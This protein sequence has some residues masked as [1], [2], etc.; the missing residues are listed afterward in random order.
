MSDA[1]R[2]Y[3][4][5]L[6]FLVFAA[7]AFAQA[8][9]LRPVGAAEGLTNSF[10]HAMAQ[11]AQGYLWI[12]TGEGVGR[13]DGNQVTMFTQADGLAENFI[14]SIHPAA[15]GTLWFGHNEGGISRLRK[16]VFR[17]VALDSLSSSTINAMVEDGHGGIWVAA[18]NNGILHVGADGTCRLSASAEGVLWYSLLQVGNGLLLAGASDGLHLLRSGPDGSLSG[19]ALLDGHTRAPVRSLVLG[20]QA[21]QVYAGT[22]GEG[23]LSFRVSGGSATAPTTIGAAEGLGTLQVRDLAIGAGGQLIIGTFGLGAYEVRLGTDGE[24]ISL[25]HYDASNGLETD[26]VS[27]VFTDS[28]N[29]LW[30]AR[31]GLGLARLL[32]RALVYYGA[33]EGTVQDVQAITFHGSDVWF[34]MQGYILHTRNNDMRLVDTLGTDLGIPDDGITA[35]A[36]GPDGALW[37]GTAKAGLYRRNAQGRFKPVELA[38][39]RMS[40]Q[41]H[42]ITMHG[43]ETWVGTS[44]GVY[45]IGAGRVRHLTTENGL[46]HNQ[47]NALLTDRSG[48]VWMACNNGGVSMARDEVV[49]SFPLT[50]GSNIFHVT[51]IAEDS[52]GTLWFS[53]NGNGVR[54]LRGSTVLGLGIGQGLR[55]DYCYAIAADG[56]G[57]I[58]TAHRG[59]AS[60]IDQGTRTVRTFDKQLGIEPDRRI[61]TLAADPDRNIWFGTDKGVLRYDVSK[62]QRSYRPPPISITTVKV[63]GKDMDLNEAIDLPPDEYRIQ[64]DFL[65]ISLKA[66][67]AVHY[68]YKLEGHDPEW[69]ETTQRSAYYMRLQDGHYIFRVQAAVGDGPFSIREANLQLTIQAPVWKRPWFIL[70]CV[71]L[72]ILSTFGIIRLREGSQRRAKERLQRKLDDRTRE[73]VTKNA[74]IELKNKDI[75]D[76]INYAQRIQ[77]AILPTEGNLAGQL[78]RSFL[79]HRPRNIVSG[80]FHWFKRSGD[81][82]I[83]ACAD[84]TGH[85]VPGAFMSMIGSMLLR[86]ITA[87]RPLHAPSGLLDRLDAE[88]R[89]V[90]HYHRVNDR[91]N[92][93]MDISICELDLSTRMLRSAAAMH[94]IIILHDGATIRQRGT[95]RSIGGALSQ[96]REAGFA[97][98][99]IQLDPGDRVYVFSDGVPDQFGGANGK[100][101]M[102]SGLIAWI[103]EFRTL[104]M[105]GQGEAFR[106]RFTEWSGEH[107]QVDDVLLIGFEV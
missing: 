61:N 96:T 2:R 81:K 34:G 23:V 10:V 40:R 75:T 19:E 35:L 101:L 30:F 37:V 3:L 25:Q 50:E 55:S 89:T 98:Q 18:Q 22:E 62:D 41:V 16:G 87:E 107:D 21:G 84:C 72:G 83:L 82:L 32:D 70:M 91:S 4:G 24:L 14:S 68:R 36:H 100:K 15:D 92:D 74:E 38:Q 39:D 104:P 5:S 13:F 43:A 7:G 12:G 94:D 1:P 48:Q 77:Q 49:R 67:G 58:W 60:R 65:G 33:D 56:H 78:P 31:F 26:N 59:G 64:F 88:L 85:G 90:L 73:L 51:G 97:L 20:G 9:K 99:G 11:D 105:S 17:K 93:G 57:G 66:P 69:T 71:L 52:S 95:R 46:M 42:A 44:N 8:Y 76:S 6:L 80:D 45:I 102:V 29:D 54:Y 27:V 53:T 63:S 47:V 86:E 106:E 79:M 28:E 103:E